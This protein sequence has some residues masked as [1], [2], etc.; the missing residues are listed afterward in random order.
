MKSNKLFPG[1]PKVFV[2]AQNN[3]VNQTVF[4]K[5]TRMERIGN[6]MNEIND[7]LKTHDRLYTSTNR[8]LEAQE[9]CL[10]KVQQMHDE[11]KNFVTL[12]SE[13]QKELKERVDVIEKQEKELEEE[14]VQLHDK[15]DCLTKQV[16]QLEIAKQYLDDEVKRQQ[17]QIINTDFHVKQ[18]EKDQ[19]NYKEQLEQLAQLVGV[20]SIDHEDLLKTVKEN[21]EEQKQMQVELDQLIT[22]VIA[23]SLQH[24]EQE[25]LHVDLYTQVT[26]LKA[27]S[28]ETTKQLKQAIS[29]LHSELKEVDFKVLEKKENRVH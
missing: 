7:S 29:R 5:N 22:K 16:R 6:Q 11:L 1:I 2:K 24:R 27:V 12:K 25:K 14:L 20:Q 17:S 13:L 26:Q 21:E 10:S 28:Y 8:R 15:K 4:Y 3:D 9:L 18:V 19:E 23:L